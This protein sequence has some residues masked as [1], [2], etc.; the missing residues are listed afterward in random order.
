MA[1]MGADSRLN[2]IKM[3]KICIPFPDIHAMKHMKPI[4]LSGAVAFAKSICFRVCDSKNAG[5]WAM[6]RH[7]VQQPAAFLTAFGDRFAWTQRMK[8]ST[9]A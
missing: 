8:P 9:P 1:W 6:Q 5:Q 7:P 4:C 3:L 2:V